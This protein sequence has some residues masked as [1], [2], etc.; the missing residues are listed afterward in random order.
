[1]NENG[2]QINPNEQVSIITDAKTIRALL[3]LVQRVPMTDLEAVAI[4]TIFGNW[5]DQIAA[6]QRM[7]RDALSKIAAM[8]G[9]TPDQPLATP[10]PNDLETAAQLDQIGDVLAHG[11]PPDNASGLLPYEND[12]QL[13][14]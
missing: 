11:S 5:F 8:A 3:T 14:G 9:M 13:V 7:Q 10:S 12:A 2:V 1:M 6:Y 4:E